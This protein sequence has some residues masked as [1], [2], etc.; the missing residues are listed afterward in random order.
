MTLGVKGASSGGKTL[1]LIKIWA[2]GFEVS[3]AI[4]SNSAADA[5][6]DYAPPVQK[7]T[8]VEVTQ[9]KFDG[10]YHFNI[11]IGPEHFSLVNKN[12]EE[13]SNVLVYASSPKFQAQPGKIRRLRIES[14]LEEIILASSLT[15][16]LTM[17]TSCLGLLLLALALALVVMWR[18]GRIKCLQNK[19]TRQDNPIL[20]FLAKKRKIPKRYSSNKKCANLCFVRK[21]ALCFCRWW[22]PTMTICVQF[23]V[24]K[25][26]R[27]L[28]T[29]QR[30]LEGLETVWA[31]G[32]VPKWKTIT[33]SMEMY[34]DTDISLL[35]P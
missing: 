19:V 20:T 15:L 32:M 23:D 1:L 29:M 2:R 35:E 26:S 33:L 8:R 30:L 10:K 6:I 3:S 12:A 24:S 4:E 17:T 11:S 16:A 5:I 25:T 28:K 21:G 14:D 27:I 18:K 31:V 7:W 13:F 9:T 22:S 34:P